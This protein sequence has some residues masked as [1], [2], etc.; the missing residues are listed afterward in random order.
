MENLEKLTSLLQNKKRLIE[1]ILVILTEEQQ[2][3]VSLDAKGLTENTKEKEEALE[4]LQRLIQ[5]IGATLAAT[6]QKMGLAAEARLSP[7]IEKAPP[8]EAGELKRLQSSLSELAEKFRR[9]TDLNGRLIKAS[10]SQVGRSLT[11]LTQ[12]SRLHGKGVYG[13]QGRMLF[14]SMERRLINEDI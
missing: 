5:E 8:R 13:Q 14:S 12:V 4:S 11:F 3:V 6:A 9:H 2:L 10:L 7:V 1:Q